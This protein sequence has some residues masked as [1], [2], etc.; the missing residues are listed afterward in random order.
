M[1]VVWTRLEVLKV[2]KDAAFLGGARIVLFCMSGICS[3]EFSTVSVDSTKDFSHRNKNLKKIKVSD[4][5][6]KLVKQVGMTIV[7]SSSIRV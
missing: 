4:A 6:E 2:I 5:V 3:V 7:V 1:A